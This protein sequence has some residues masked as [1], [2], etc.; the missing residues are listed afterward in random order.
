METDETDEERLH[1]QIVHNLRS[2]G[3]SKEDAVEEADAKIARWRERTK[4]DEGKRG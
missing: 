3:W 4:R 1:A 2:N